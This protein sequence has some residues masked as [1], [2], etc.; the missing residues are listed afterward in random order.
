MIL[1]QGLFEEILLCRRLE[2]NPAHT[3]RRRMI[4]HSHTNR[5]HGRY[6]ERRRYRCFSK[7]TGRLTKQ[8]FAKR[9]D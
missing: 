7:D 3:H 8:R 2:C 5:E 4:A 9:D 6:L 1:A